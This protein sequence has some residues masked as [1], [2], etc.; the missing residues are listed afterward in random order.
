[1][2]NTGLRS[3]WAMA[4]AMFC[5]ART[6][7]RCSVRVVIGVSCRSDRGS[8]SG[9]V[10]VGVAGKTTAERACERSAVVDQERWWLPTLLA[11]FLSTLLGAA[12]L[13]GFLG[14]AFL[15]SLLGRALLGATLLGGLLG[16]GL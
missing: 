8:V 2:P 4:A 15:G 5:D 6:R 3:S 11:A 10:M 13:R 9:P 1:M 12:L 7:S 14:T 16:R